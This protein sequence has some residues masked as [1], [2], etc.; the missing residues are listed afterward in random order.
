MIRRFYPLASRTVLILARRLAHPVIVD[1]FLRVT[2]DDERRSFGELKQRTTIK[3]R[4]LLAEYFEVN[5]QN[6]CRL[7]A[8][9][10]FAGF[11]VV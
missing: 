9:Y 3:R 1:F 6:R 8:M 2:V 4:Q 10:F 7:L 5:G 11:D